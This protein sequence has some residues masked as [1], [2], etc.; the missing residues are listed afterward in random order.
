MGNLKPEPSSFFGE[1][2]ASWMVK[3]DGNLKLLSFAVLDAAL[4]SSSEEGGG[5]GNL[6]WFSFSILDATLESSS[7]EGG[8]VGSRNIAVSA[9]CSCGLSQLSVQAVASQILGFE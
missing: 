6:K 8:G 4:E 9:T 1:T 2:L 7:E 3:F 5:V